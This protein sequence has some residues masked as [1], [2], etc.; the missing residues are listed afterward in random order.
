[1]KL[2]KDLMGVFYGAGFFIMKVIFK[3]QKQDLID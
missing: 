1:M 2:L 3:G